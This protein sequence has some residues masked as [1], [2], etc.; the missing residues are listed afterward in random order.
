MSSNGSAKLSDSLSTKE[1][2]NYNITGALAAEANK[3]DI[4]TKDKPRAIVLKYHEPSDAR[5]PSASEIWMLYVFKGNAKDPLE[6]IPLHTRSCWLL[7]RETAVADIPLDH[8]SLSKQHCVLQWRG[9]PRKDGVGLYVLDLESSNGTTLNGT[10]IEAAR[11]IECKS[12][13]VLRLGESQRD[14]VI[15]QA[16]QSS[17]ANL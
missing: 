3:V 15:L 16:P 4:G 13:D 9:K 12:N 17:M 1:R 6:T 5:K 11:F 14:Y 7:G 8:P 10:R 2:P